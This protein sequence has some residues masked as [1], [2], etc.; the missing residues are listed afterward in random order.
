MASPADL[1]VLIVTYNSRAFVGECIDAVVTGVR[2]H[3]VEIVV[4]DNA[5]ADGSA[6]YVRAGFPGVDVIDIGRNAGFAVANNRAW[7]QSRGRHVVLLNGDA[8]VTPGALDILVEFLDEHP[9]A[10]VVAPQLLNPD[11]SDQGT[12]RTFPTPAA[13]VFGRR[14]PL[15]RL[16][17][18]NRYS[19]RYLAGREHT[20]DEP[21]AVDWVSGA[22]RM[23]P[24]RIVE[25][26]G[27]LDEGFFMHWEDADWC[28]RVKAAGFGVWC[29]PAARVVHA[30]GG[31]RGGWPAVQV[32]HFHRSAYR[33]YAKHHLTG[34]R[35]VLRPVA[36]AALTA[37]ASLII[38][39]D[40]LRARSATASPA[41]VARGDVRAG[42]LR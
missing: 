22:C 12:A 7:K 24:R 3:T 30:E 9:D 23:I 8:I 41:A 1:S 6:D 4:A 15:T 16:F 32:R 38:G 11:G 37:R 14:S 34:A 27:P 31:S 29:V 25:R 18:R 33:Y 21:F 20:G 5:S 10:G 19:R 36:R 28:R 42:D 35:R 17:P 39:R 2:R 40:A 13:A 26:V